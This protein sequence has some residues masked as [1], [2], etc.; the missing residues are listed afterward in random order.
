MD[1]GPALELCPLCP[2]AE[3]LASHGDA[4]STGAPSVHSGNHPL[5][6]G[7]NHSRPRTRPRHDREPATEDSR[8]EHGLRQS[9]TA[10]EAVDQ[11]GQA[12]LEPD[13]YG[14]DGSFCEVR[15]MTFRTAYG[16]FKTFW[17]VDDGVSTCLREPPNLDRLVSQYDAVYYGDFCP[18]CDDLSTGRR[19]VR[20][21]KPTEA[22]SSAERPR[23]SSHGGMDL[24]VRPR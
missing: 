12:Y 21:I 6:H 15:R 10:K 18:I 2:K 24:P 5:E 4:T 20:L 7:H 16:T 1:S 17:C 9:T 22:P 8:G 3:K 11:H 19:W 13:D 23:V 14:Y